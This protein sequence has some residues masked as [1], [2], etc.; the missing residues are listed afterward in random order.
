MSQGGSA[1]KT[2]VEYKRDPIS[3]Q[4]GHLDPETVLCAQCTSL[5]PHTS[6]LVI[7]P[8][9]ACNRYLQ[10]KVDFTPKFTLYHIIFLHNIHNDLLNI[11][12]DDYDFHND[13][14]K[15]YDTYNNFYNAYNNIQDHIFTF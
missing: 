15:F 9:A 12:N 5:Y 8:F 6:R 2:F 7:G 13:D 1:T 3:G 10:Y 4:E 11:S 14:Y